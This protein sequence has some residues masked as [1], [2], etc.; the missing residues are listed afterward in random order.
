MAFST[1]L[2]SKS[3]LPITLIVSLHQRARKPILRLLRPSFSLASNF[4][5]MVTAYIDLFPIRLSC[6]TSIRTPLPSARVPQLVWNQTDNL[7]MSDPLHTTKGRV[8]SSAV[9]SPVSELLLLPPAPTILLFPPV[10]NSPTGHSDS[11]GIPR[12]LIPAPYLCLQSPG[13]PI[14]LPCPDEQ[15]LPFFRFPN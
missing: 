1:P 12:N 8:S 3:G 5:G 13:P 6:S 11:L 2:R 15:K 7:S 10:P 14:S 4:L 9:P